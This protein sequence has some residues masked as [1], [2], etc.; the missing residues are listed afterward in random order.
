MS[1][2]VLPFLLRGAWVRV[3]IDG[4]QT[5]LRPHGLTLFRLKAI[6]PRIMDRLDVLMGG[7]VPRQP[8]IIATASAVSNR[9]R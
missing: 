5:G 9:S 4:E 6:R 2:A 7:I 1:R 3:R 8:M